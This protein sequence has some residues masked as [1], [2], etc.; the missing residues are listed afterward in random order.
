VDIAPDGVRRIDPPSTVVALLDRE[1]DLTL[2]PTAPDADICTQ[3]PVFA[4]AAAAAA[5]V[6]GD[7][8]GRLVPV[9][10]F[11]TEARHSSTG[12]KPHPPLASRNALP[13]MVPARNESQR[14]ASPP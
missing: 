5:W 10:D 3:Q 4:S 8:A 2:D 12:S 14:S 11:H 1:V 13:R 9:R 7:P 6:A